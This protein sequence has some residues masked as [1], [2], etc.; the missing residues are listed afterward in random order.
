MAAEAESDRDRPANYTHAFFHVATG[1][2]EGE[3]SLHR[4]STPEATDP[5]LLFLH[6]NGFNG[7]T[8]NR[9]LTRIG[10]K[11]TTLAI[12]LRGHGR[13]TLPAD[14]TKVR[15]WFRY[16]DDVIAAIDAL[17]D[18]GPFVL[19]GHSMGG[20]TAF[21]VAAA[22][23]D[24]VSRI[25]AFEPV[26]IPAG[27]KSA[28][29]TARL[30]IPGFDLPMAATAERRRSTFD[31]REAI[32]QSYRGRGAFATWPDEMIRDY[33]AGGTVEND[34]GTIELACRPAWEAANY[35]MAGMPVWRTFAKMKCPVRILYGQ[36]PRS[37]TPDWIVKRLARDYD[38]LETKRYEDCGHFLP[39]EIYRTAIDEINAWLEKSL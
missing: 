11:H 13:T 17:P 6:A 24:L 22:R 39:M 18:D 2:G 9:I 27:L 19:A 33:I 36:G 30:M 28:I 3:V 26:L 10:E 37:T 7:F 5:K 35:R 31:N 14:P 1:W 16:R 4:W 38:G 15:N 32:F 23:P 8:Y 21:L 20:A 25:I 34:D 12:D 29:R